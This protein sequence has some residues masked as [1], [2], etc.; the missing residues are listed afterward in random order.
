VSVW[1]VV[2]QVVDVAL[3]TAIRLDRYLDEKMARKRR[4]L[5]F[6]DVRR[7]QA[8]IASATKSRA[9]TVILRRPPR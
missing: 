1:A 7:Q 2:W 6:E 4:G 5:S 8:Q 9:P 3:H